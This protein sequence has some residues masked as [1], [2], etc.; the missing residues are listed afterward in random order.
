[1]PA[2]S[3]KY[4][5]SIDVIKIKPMSAQRTIVWWYLAMFLVKKTAIEA[6]AVRKKKKAP[7]KPPATMANRYA[8]V[9]APDR[10]LPKNG[11]FDASS[12]IEAHV[13]SRVFPR[14][15]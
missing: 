12:Y 6:R 10:P 7:N 13:S 9:V 11:S 15:A 3:N 5:S 1:M 2:A 14:L 4:P 8:L